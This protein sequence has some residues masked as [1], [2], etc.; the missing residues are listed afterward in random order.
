MLSDRKIKILEAIIKDYIVHGEPISSRTIEKKHNLGISSATIR[1]EMSDLEEMGLIVQPHASSGRIPTDAGYRMHVDRMEI[2]GLG[3]KE[4][5]YLNEIIVSNINNMEVLMKET[6][7]AISVL[8]NYT[9]IVSEAGVKRLVIRYIQL[10][11]LDA[12]SIVVTVITVSK[13]IKNA[14]LSVDTELDINTLNQLTAFLNHILRDK[15]VEDITGIIIEN[16][17][18]KHL[19]DSILDIIAKIL[20]SEEEIEVFTSGVNKILTYP[21]FSN[22][23]KAEGIFKALEE[24]EILINLL[25]KNDSDNVQVIIGSENALEQVQDCS[26]IKANYQG[27]GQSVGAI[28]IIGPKRMDYYNAVSILKEVV[29]NINSVLYEVTTAATKSEDGGTTE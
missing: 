2:S 13:V 14:A 20:T 11:P 5:A 9:T 12:N 7:K 18:H 10:M 29:K 4:R 15:T 17:P 25:D 28:G 8:T 6:A 3:E 23:S 16:S 22:V 19:L 26:I 21:E 24:K 27:A 1:N